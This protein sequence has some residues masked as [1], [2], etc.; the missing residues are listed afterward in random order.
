MVVIS[1]KITVC[2]DDTEMVL[3]S[4]SLSVAKATAADSKRYALPTEAKA[5][6]CAQRL[7]NPG[8]HRL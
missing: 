6:P 3:V 8:E 2:R 4:H 7:G 1:T 5:I